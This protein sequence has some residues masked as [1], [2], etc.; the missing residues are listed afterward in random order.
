MWLAGT[1]EN[2]FRT[3]GYLGTQ[4]DL[5][6]VPAAARRA[7]G[8]QRRRRPDRSCWAACGESFMPSQSTF[9]F[10]GLRNDNPLRPLAGPALVQQ[11]GRTGGGGGKPWEA[12]VWA[13]ASSDRAAAEGAA[14]GQALSQQWRG[15]IL[16]SGWD[17][18]K[19]SDRHRGRLLL[20]AHWRPR[21]LRRR[22]IL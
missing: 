5:L 19:K 9:A 14:A 17:L 16:R 12:I 4:P 22:D 10:Y 3:C 8:M 1:G 18:S 20:P 7:L 2:L 13:D 15:R 6:H 11:A 21:A